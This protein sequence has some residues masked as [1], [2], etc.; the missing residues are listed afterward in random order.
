MIVLDMM[1][2]DPD[3]PEVGAGYVPEIAR[4]INAELRKRGKGAKAHLV[5]VNYVGAMCERYLTATEDDGWG[6]GR[7]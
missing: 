1:G 6:R 5:A 2:A 4:S 3:H 7:T